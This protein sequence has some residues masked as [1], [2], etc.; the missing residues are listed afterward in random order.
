[1]SPNWPLRAFPS[2]STLTVGS[3]G[4]ELLVHGKG[5]RE[6]VIP[7]ADDLSALI[8]GGSLLHTPTQISF[9]GGFRPN[10]DPFDAD[11]I[12]AGEALRPGIARTQMAWDFEELDRADL[13]E[14]INRWLGGF[15]QAAT[16]T[17]QRP[18]ISVEKPHVEP[19]RWWQT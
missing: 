17:L 9:G 6:R 15:G 19:A 7:I 8:A 5:D 14:F 18:G 10:I 11:G 4:A 16:G 2:Q 1:M 12:D 13:S 3:C